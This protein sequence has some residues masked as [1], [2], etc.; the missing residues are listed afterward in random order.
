MTGP[1]VYLLHENDEWVEPLRAPL[2][3]LGTPFAEWHL[4]RDELRPGTPPPGIFYGKIS[5]SAHTRGHRSA[6]EIG[7][8][9]LEWL[10]SAGC[11]VVNGSRAVDLEISKARQYVGLAEHGIPVPSYHLVSGPDGIRRAAA[12][13]GFPL[14]V[15][16]NRGGKGAGVMRF[17]SEAGLEHTLGEGRFEAGPDGLFIVQAAI[18]APD[19]TITRCEFV[20]GAFLYAVQVDTRG[21]FELCPADVCEI[22][23][24]FCATDSRA[25]FEIRADFTP[26]YL[27]QYEAF[28]DANGVKIAGI[29]FIFDET[30]RAWT[31][32]VNF[33]T[34]YNTPAET[35]AGLTGTNRAGIN[36][37]AAF[38]DS[39]L[40]RHYPEAANA[41]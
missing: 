10:Q 14:V 26:P 8:A 40:K 23:E 12:H 2:Q 18:T 5:A 34:N 41:A 17:E 39:E 37:V 35:A 22:G 27:P 25:P 38:L 1:K 24:A 4:A 9:I 31:Y 3:A 30:G 20:G 21:G 28:L 32:D 6:P 11:V 13:L 29:E 7:A 33:N 36:A 15:K 16:P 19:Q